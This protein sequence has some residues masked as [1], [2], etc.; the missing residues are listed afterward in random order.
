M[1]NQVFKVKGFV[2]QYCKTMKSNE[3]LWQ[4]F[5][6]LAIK[7]LGTFFAFLL[8]IKLANLLPPSS[9]GIYFIVLMVLTVGSVLSRAGLENVLL[10][11]IAEF[12]EEGRPGDLKG[13]FYSGVLASLLITVV[14]TVLVYALAPQL[15]LLFNVSGLERDIRTMLWGII[16]FTFIAL[17]A[18]SLKGLRHVALAQILESLLIPFI[19]LLLVYFFVSYGELRKVEMFYVT[20]LVI[21]M[22]VAFIFWKKVTTSFTE[23]I[24]SFSKRSLLIQGRPLLLV[25]SFN[26]IIMWIGTVAL[27]VFSN[28][29]EVA[30]YNIATRVA[31]LTSFILIAVNSAS[32]AKFASLYK[33]GN[34]LALERMGLQ[35]TVLIVIL[36]I[37]ILVVFL[38]FPETVIS[39]FGES[40]NESAAVLSILA[41][42]QLFTVL[43]GSI[44]QILIMT[45]HG[46]E[47]RN[48]MF[49]GVVAQSLLA[50]LLVP[51]FGAI[52]A[53][54][55]AASCSAIINIFSAVYV[56][57]CLAI[58]TT[59]IG[60]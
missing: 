48:A 51:Q 38:V 43:T 12:K 23:E 55:S 4:S 32:S 41:A 33:K 22:V 59:L 17:T 1:L 2:F 44:G 26:L 60:V 50:T 52:G 58:K 40:Y 56:R 53:A 15:A 20:S 19:A 6:A 31:V 18:A 36:S 7:V 45:G 3:L 42:G 39:L 34:I 16:P 47:L 37:P 54:I 13:A 8:S 10:R 30:I 49:F 29:E 21:T 35:S 14:V 28:T 46:K 57:K 24:S 11:L 9:L 27:G 25:S 5:Q